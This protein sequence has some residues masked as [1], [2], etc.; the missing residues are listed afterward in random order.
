[1]KKKP[2]FL[3]NI[4][5]IKNNYTISENMKKQHVD[6]RV[7]LFYD[8]CIPK[9]G[10]VPMVTD[11]QY[12]ELLNRVKEL[13]DKLNSLSRAMA[14]MAMK[15]GTRTSRVQEK[16]V[17]PVIHKDVTKYIFNGEMLAKRQLV[18][19][20][21][22]QYAADKQI[23]EGAELIEAF[24]DYLQGSLGVVRKAEDAELYEDSKNRYFFEDENVLQM[25]DGTFVV[26]KDWTVKNINRFLKTAETAGYQFESINRE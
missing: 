22:K 8:I 4:N 24:P 9:K 1:M 21:I 16:P 19:H 18:L 6:L 5:N 13:E 7:V 26:C 3:I 23:T 10:E 20:V 17:D 15:N 11:Q 12:K 25:N 2:P 14:E